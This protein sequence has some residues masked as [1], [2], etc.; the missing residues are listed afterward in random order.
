MMQQ[1]SMLLTGNH[2]A[3]W[4]ARLARPQVVPVYPITPQTPILELLTDF[5]A[6]GEMRAEIL[7]PESEH[8]VLSACVPASLAGARV[9][10]ATASQGA[11]LMHEVLHYASGARAPIVMANVNRTVASPW[12]FWPDQTDSLAQRDT[13]WLQFYVET[14]QETLDTVLHAFRLAEQVQLPAMV[15]LDAFYV[16]H[17]LEPVQVPAQEAVDRYLPPY[18]PEHRLD[19]AVGSSWGNVVGQDMYYRHRQMIE[20]AMARAIPLAQEADREWAELSGRSHGVLERYRCDGAKAVV[21]T[22]GSMCGTAREAVDALR[23]AGEPVGLL[24]LRLFRPFPV[25]ALRVAL[26]AVPDVIVLDRNHSPG[27]GGILH[28]ELKAALYGLQ[29]PPRV[30]GLLAGVGGVNVSPEAM[31]AMVRTALAGAPRVESSWV[32]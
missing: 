3:A 4:A 28:Q 7:T 25:Q 29:A 32:R 18:A 23:A 1:T 21:V 14:A 19:P 2:A 20:D 27:L 10:T 17:A 8:S 30:H 16:S 22:M 6:R 13:G 15:N 12:A 26:G 31:A 24:K 11:L 5:H 9:F